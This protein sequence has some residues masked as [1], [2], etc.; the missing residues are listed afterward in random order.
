MKAW[1][2]D[3]IFCLFLSFS[4]LE[5]EEAVEVIFIL[6]FGNLMWFAF[7]FRGV[8]ANIPGNSFSDFPVHDAAKLV[9]KLCEVPEKDGYFEI[10]QVD[11]TNLMKVTLFFLTL[12]GA[13]SFHVSSSGQ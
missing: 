9:G 2:S 10:Y 5:I 8:R 1:S 11:D 4:N 12:E 6:S 3:D 13:R 7:W